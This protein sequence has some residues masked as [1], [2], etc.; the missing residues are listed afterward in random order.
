[1]TSYG[2]L[3][4]NGTINLT[5]A[6]ILFYTLITIEISSI[7]FVIGF[8]LVML[9]FFMAIINISGGGKK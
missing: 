2:I 1:M 7:K 8:F 4:I 9:N 6:L 5:V 3:E